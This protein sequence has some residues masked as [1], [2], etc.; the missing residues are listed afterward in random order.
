MRMRGEDSHASIAIDLADAYQ[1]ATRQITLRLPG[2]GLG[3]ARERTLDVTIPKGVTAGR[4]L[5]LSGQGQAGSG[6]APA[7]DL[8]LE[9]GFNPDPFY[10]VEGRDVF[11]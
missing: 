6:G 10:Q 11:V 5:R 9:I 2:G 7:G 4:Q 8:Y 1:G 3:G